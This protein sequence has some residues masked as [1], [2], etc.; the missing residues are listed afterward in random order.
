MPSPVR[1][2]TN[3]RAPACRALW[4]HDRVPRDR[5]PW[6]SGVIRH[7]SSVLGLILVLCAAFGPARAHALDCPGVST[8]LP[9]DCSGPGG[10][11]DVC[12]VDIAG[13]VTCDLTYNGDFGSGSVHAISDTSADD[14]TVWGTDGDGNT[15]CCDDLV[16]GPNASCSTVGTSYADAM[17]LHYVPSGTSTL[18]NLDRVCVLYGMDGN[19]TQHGSRNAAVNDVIYGGDGDDV[20]KGF[21]GDDGLSGQDGEDSLFGGDGGDSVSGGNDNDLIFGEGNLYGAQYLAGDGGDDVIWGGDDHEDIDGGQGADR[22]RSQGGNDDVDGGIGDDSIDTG[23]GHDTAHGG[24]GDD[25]ICT[26]DGN[27]FAYGEDDLDTIFDSS[28]ADTVDGGSSMFDVCR[29]GILHE[30]NPACEVAVSACPW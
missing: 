22:I 7:P 29:N 18:H 28:G 6:R 2:L 12:Q 21:E 4:Y 3:H 8:T 11:Y 20:A 14:L 26:G 10:T 5:G 23:D 25:R 13:N 19:D 15:F 16:V 1:Q 30:S 24:D 17:K 9:D 27:D